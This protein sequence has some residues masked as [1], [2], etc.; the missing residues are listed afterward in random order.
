[1]HHLNRFSINE[2]GYTCQNGTNF[3]KGTDHTVIVLFAIKAILYWAA[4][5]AQAAVWLNIP[6]ALL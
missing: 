1:M 3:Y 5:I 6:P 2:K 4:V